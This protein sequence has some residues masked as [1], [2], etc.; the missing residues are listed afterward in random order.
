M[1]TTTAKRLRG[2][3]WAAAAL[4][5]GMTTTGGV[6]VAGESGTFGFGEVASEADIAAINI[7]VMPDG[8]GAPPG[9]GTHAEGQKV[10]QAKCQACHGPDLGGVSGTGGA[11]L[12]GGRGSLAS[13]SPKKTV[14]S[15]WPYASTVFDFV[16]RAM[17][18]DAPGSLSNDEIYAVTAFVL[19]EGGII[20][21]TTV[22]DASN[23]GEVQMPNR[24]GFVPDPRP[25]VHN[26]R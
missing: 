12:I 2:A 23:I 16:K 26:Y 7:D 25:D 11:A 4:L 21:K 13:G 15:Y 3:A 18:F 14:E 9:Q 10:Y 20:D 19:A 5:G 22:L 17:P 24:D 8:R 1:S 6:A